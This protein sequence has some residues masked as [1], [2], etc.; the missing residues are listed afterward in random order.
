M[1]TNVSQEHIA[2]TFRV[3]S[4][5]RKQQAELSLIFDPDDGRT[6]CSSET[7]AD[8]DRTTR[9]ISLLHAVAHEPSPHCTASALTCTREVLASSFGRGTGYPA[10]CLLS[11]TPGK[12]RLNT[13]IRQCYHSPEQSSFMISWDVVAGEI[14]TVNRQGCGRKRYWPNLR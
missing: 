7:S 2:S 13:S 9:A 1:S 11:V 4:Q 10:S 6:I 3:I 14:P 5:E 8:T 12:W